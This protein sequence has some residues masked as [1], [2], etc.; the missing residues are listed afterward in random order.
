M[1][2]YSHYIFDFDG[3]LADS[4]VYWQLVQMR[5][6]QSYGVPTDDADYDYCMTHSA[7]DRKIYFCEKYHLSEDRYPTYEEI[8]QWIDRFYCSSV[9]WKEGAVEFL[10][11]ARAEGKTTVLFSATP[12]EILF[13]A[14]EHLDAKQYFDY[15][16]SASDI[17]IGKSDPASYEYCLRTIGAAPRDAVMFEDAPYSMKTA[18]SLGLRVVAVRESAMM[19]QMN[20]I[21][22]NSDEYVSRLSE[23]SG[24]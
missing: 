19:Y 20:A 6:L 13:H 12:K 14:L 8:L 11:K 3:T 24:K 16:I 1:S 9:Q 2:G 17:G 18:R 4:Q 15:I 7:A 22:E 23:W 21:L 5:I 10:C